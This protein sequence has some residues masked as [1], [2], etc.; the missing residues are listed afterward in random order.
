[1]SKYEGSEKSTEFDPNKWKM[2]FECIDDAKAD[3][4][5]FEDKDEVTDDNTVDSIIESNDEVIS[6]K[7]KSK[8]IKIII[9]VISVAIISV[10][11]FF[12]VLGIDYQLNTYTGYCGNNAT[13]KITKSD[14]FS[15]NTVFYSMTIEG[16]GPLWTADKIDWSLPEG[17]ITYI[18]IKDG[19][20]RINKDQ[21][22][23]FD[24][25]Y[26]VTI[27]KSVIFIG[28]SAFASNEY[29]NIDVDSPNC[30]IDYI[31]N[32]GYLYETL[33]PSNGVTTIV[34]RKNSTTEEYIKT[35]NENYPNSYEMIIK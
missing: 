21:F 22:L 26:Y 12:A 16:S 18:D 30:E 3:N 34:C 23:L 8:I 27:P 14:F 7:S 5:I 9:A 28:K 6:N 31:D 33:G 25:L 32:D 24:D 15:I 19:I 1:M 17:Q 20:T 13:Y 2:G 4:G 35:W 10:A 29:M 11:T